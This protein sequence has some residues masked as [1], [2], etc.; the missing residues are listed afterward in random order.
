MD[1]ARAVLER[2]ERIDTLE[3]SGAPASVLLD[4]VRGLLAD[5]EAWV[6]TES[7]G[8]DLAETALERCR[9]VLQEVQQGE[10]DRLKPVPLRA[11]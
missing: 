5:A 3:A 8:T 4:E 2:L 11:V 6:R 10:G 9:D 7:G 1:E